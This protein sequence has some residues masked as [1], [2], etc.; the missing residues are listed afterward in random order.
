MLDFILA[1][2]NL[3]F[4]VALALMAM[5]GLV[6]ALGLGLGAIDLDADVQADG[7]LLGWLGVGTVP[8]LVLIIV[9]LA[10]FG[11]IG[12]TIQQ[13][14][15]ALTGSP[16]SPWLAAPAALAAALPLTGGAAR[17]LARILPKDE[18][19]AV[20]IATLVGK[21][22]TVTVGVARRG[23]PAQARVRDAHGQSH[24]VM[25]EPSGDH[26]QVGAGETMLLVRREDGVFIGLYEGEALAALDDRP[27][28]GRN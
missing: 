26:Q 25:V 17:A 24:Y 28:L 8:L 13:V 7:D 14:A 11:L 6:E 19:T 5:I 1:P 20:D 2:E 23:S 10:L 4:A 9:L 12:V 16:L 15:A 3:P 22:A 18:T 27:A 21:R